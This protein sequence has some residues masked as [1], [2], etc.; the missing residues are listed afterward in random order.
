MLQRVPYD[1]LMRQL[2]V[3]EVRALEDLLI[4]D[5]F[6]PKLITGKLDQKEGALVVADAAGRDVQ[7]DRLPNV[8]AA[9]SSWCAAIVCHKHLCATVLLKGFS[10]GTRKPCLLANCDYV[11]TAR[12]PSPPLCPAGALLLLKQCWSQ[13]AQSS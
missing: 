7:P 1:H 10:H 6:Y 3:S 4:S 13:P 12:P 5:C 2:G 8:S 11:R 9:L